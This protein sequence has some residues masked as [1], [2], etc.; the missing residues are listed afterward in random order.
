MGRFSVEIPGQNTPIELGS[1]E[2]TI[3]PNPAGLEALGSNLLAESASTG[4]PVLVR[5]G[6]QGSG[7]LASGTLEGQMSGLLMK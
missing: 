3:F 4:R 1:L 7:T 2:L 6:E 5:P